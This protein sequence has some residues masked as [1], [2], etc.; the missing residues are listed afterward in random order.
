[1]RRPQSWSDAANMPRET[2]V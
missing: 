1:M 2:G